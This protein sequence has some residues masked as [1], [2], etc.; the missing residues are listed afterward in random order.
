MVKKEASAAAG[1]QQYLIDSA[2]QR[3][4]YHGHP[5]SQVEIDAEILDAGHPAAQASA[6][7]FGCSRERD[8]RHTE[9]RH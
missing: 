7:R 3:L 9:H 1:R 2:I 6:G 4:G 8:L 5:F